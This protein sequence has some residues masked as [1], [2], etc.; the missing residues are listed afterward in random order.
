MA[1]L[2][3]RWSSSTTGPPSL[4]PGFGLVLECGRNGVRASCGPDL[5]FAGLYS[6]R[7]MARVVLEI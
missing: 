4:S 3:V 6:S 1:V 7:L 5:D 2:M